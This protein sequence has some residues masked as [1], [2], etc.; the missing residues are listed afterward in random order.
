MATVQRVIECHMM[1]YSQMDDG[2][3]EV[4]NALD[5]VSREI[6][7]LESASVRRQIPYNLFCQ[8]ELQRT[9]TLSIFYFSL[10]AAVFY[11]VLTRYIFNQLL[12]TFHKT[13]LQNLCVFMWPMVSE[14]IHSFIHSLFQAQGP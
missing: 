6:D 4:Y 3:N 2:F 14:F 11:C 5:D 12:S 10:C 7:G 9:V 8:V 13:K 1:W